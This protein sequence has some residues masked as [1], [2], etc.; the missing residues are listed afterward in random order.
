MARKPV[1]EGGKRDEIIEVAT[2]LFFEKGYEETSVRDVLAVVGGEIGMFYHYF[3][4][5]EELFQV[6]AQ[7]FFASYKKAVAEITEQCSDINRFVQSFLA[8]YNS[9]VSK[10]FKLFEN[11][12]WTL[13]LAFMEG[14]CEELKEPVEKFLKKLE[15]KADTA[16]DVMVNQFVYGLNGTIRAKSFPTLNDERKTAVLLE[17]L[18]DI[19]Y[20]EYDKQN[21][22]LLKNIEDG[23]V[24][25]AVAISAEKKKYSRCGMRCDLC[26]MYRPNVEREDRRAELAAVFHK[27]SP[28]W[29]PNVDTLLCDGCDPKTPG[30]V[31]FSPACKARECVKNHNIE[32]CGY[33][34]EYEGC[35]IFPAELS[36]DQLVQKID[37]EK[38]W[39]WD[40]EK[41]MACYN[42]KQFMD[43]FRAEH[44]MK[45]L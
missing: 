39:T 26:L 29:N 35:K 17:F 10:Y 37:V 5:K 32:H 45:L 13:K 14:L 43:A 44:G 15:N 9:D 4:S 20:K 3:K 33:C 23:A 18:N 1:L 16:L 42:C 31:Q 41:L 30:A 36:H 28:K 8:Y 24:G 21:T 27:I 6:V 38:K 19:I 34:N 12:H 40:D 25:E 2:K 7:K 11:L 22:V